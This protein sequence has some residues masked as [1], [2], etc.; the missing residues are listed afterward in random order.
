MP[1]PLQNSCKQLT[2][3][4]RPVKGKERWGREKRDYFFFFLEKIF[5]CSSS[6]FSMTRNQ[7]GQNP[8]VTIL[9][10]K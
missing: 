7:Y 6:G 5:C 2:W 10:K 9:G 1:G 3:I 4:L 8:R